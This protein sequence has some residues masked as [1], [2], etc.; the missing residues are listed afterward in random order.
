MEVRNKSAFTEAWLDLQLNA[1]R[2]EKKKTTTGLRLN[3][4]G[5][6][7]SFAVVTIQVVGGCG[8]GQRKKHSNVFSVHSGER[9]DSS[10]TRGLHHQFD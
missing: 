9:G 4:T 1:A 2:K 7:G 8:S 3:A 5:S 6:L 10:E